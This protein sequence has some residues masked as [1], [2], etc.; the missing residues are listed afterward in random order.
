MLGLPG[1][2]TRA[3]ALNVLTTREELPKRRPGA[4]RPELMGVRRV[5]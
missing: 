1:D 2:G 4:S 3:E 5:A